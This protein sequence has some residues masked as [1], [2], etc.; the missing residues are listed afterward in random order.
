MAGR[1]IAEILKQILKRGGRSVPKRLPPKPSPPVPKPPAP[2]PPAPKPPPPKPAPKPKPRDKK[3]DCKDCKGAAKC[4]AFA[5]GEEGG[6]HGFMKG[7]SGDGKDSHHM[8]A[9]SASPLPRDAGPAIKMD[10]ADHKRTASHGSGAAAKKYQATQRKLIAQGK[11]RQAFMMD[12]ADVKA[13]FGNKYNKGLAEAIAYMECL[14][15]N[16]VVK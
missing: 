14:K 15:R 7:P 10:P 5:N 16:K 12:V 3:K 1:I 8:P 2:K 11:F 9:A 6:A 13:K 4:A